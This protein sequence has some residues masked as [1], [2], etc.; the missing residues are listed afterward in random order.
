MR[1]ALTEAAK[2]GHAAVLLVGDASYYGRFGFS[3]DKTRTLRLSGADRAR[4]LAVELKP[5]ALTGTHGVIAA[6]GER[7][8]VLPSLG[9]LKS[10]AQL[11]PRAA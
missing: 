8:R 4:L 1:R 2:R 9:R 5:D 3:A 10:G 6:A 7:E 11:I